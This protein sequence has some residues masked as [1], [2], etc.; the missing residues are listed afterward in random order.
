MFYPRWLQRGL[1]SAR[2]GFKLSAMRTL[3]W[4]LCRLRK[5]VAQSLQGRLFE[6]RST[7]RPCSSKTLFGSKR[8]SKGVKGKFQSPSAETAVTM[9]ASSSAENTVGRPGFPGWRP[10][11]LFINVPF[12]IPYSCAAFHD[13]IVPRWTA[14]IASARCWNV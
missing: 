7:T 2:A 11:S 10:F 14:E 3:I 12:G 8:S 4:L 6:K 9:L 1:N 5:L 13:F